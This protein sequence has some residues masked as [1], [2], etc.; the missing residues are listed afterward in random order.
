MIIAFILEA[1]FEKQ[2]EMAAAQ[3]AV[4]LPSWGAD[5]KGGRRRKRKT[6]RRRRGAAGH[7]DDDDDDDDDEDS[8]GGGGG[9]GVSGDMEEPSLFH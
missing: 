7:N 4:S 1:F 6:Q 8:G 5:G 9:G 2:E 3:P